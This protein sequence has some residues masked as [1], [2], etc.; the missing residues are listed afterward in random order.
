MFWP[1]LKKKNVWL[2]CKTPEVQA[3]DQLTGSTDLTLQRL[4]L[5]KF[6]QQKLLFKKGTLAKYI[7]L[8][9]YN[10]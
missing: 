7:N 5:I 6:S 10:V 2:T 3:T 9:I 4:N 1:V 8:F